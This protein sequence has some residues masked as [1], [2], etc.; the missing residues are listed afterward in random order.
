LTVNLYVQIIG[1]ERIEL[2]DQIDEVLL[3]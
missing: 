1:F 2:I 3:I